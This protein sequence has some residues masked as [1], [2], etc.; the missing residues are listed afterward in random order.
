MALYSAGGDRRAGEP[1]DV[2]RALIDRAEACLSR[3][4]SSSELSR[5]NALPG[6]PVPVGPDLWDVV[7]RAME[8]AR[9]TRGLYDPAT[10]GALESAGL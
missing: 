3:F 8:G 1:L 5:L 2:A 6:R 7:V 9:R 10:L 4:R